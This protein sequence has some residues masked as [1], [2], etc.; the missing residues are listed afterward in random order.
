MGPGVR[1]GPGRSGCW[2]GLSRAIT[3]TVCGPGMEGAIIRRGAQVVN[4]GTTDE[5]GSFLGWEGGV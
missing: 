1:A 4:V 2:T 3:E 5:G